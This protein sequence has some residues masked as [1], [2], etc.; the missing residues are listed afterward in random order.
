MFFALASSRLVHNMTRRPRLKDDYPDL[1]NAMPQRLGLPSAMLVSS[2]IW[3]GKEKRKK[4]TMRSVNGPR[5]SRICQMQSQATPERH[6]H[7]KGTRLPPPAPSLLMQGKLDAVSSGI[8]FW[9][10]IGEARERR[11]AA[12]VVQ[13]FA[14]CRCCSNIW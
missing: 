4:K 1:W 8:S 6:S 9:D 12:S 10:K 5:S 3:R 11:P 2:C 14:G 7:V 13:T